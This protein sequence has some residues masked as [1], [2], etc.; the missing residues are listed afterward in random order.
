M[1]TSSFCRDCGKGMYWVRTEAGKAMPLDLLPT[2][3]EYGNVVL[4]GTASRG[5]STPIAHVLTKAEKAAGTYAHLQH[6][7]MHR[8]TC[9]KA[10]P[11][12]QLDL[13]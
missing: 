7:V 4:V 13:D 3:K 2:T 1:S 11:E 10:E 8:A 12:P 5:D 6:W 9:G